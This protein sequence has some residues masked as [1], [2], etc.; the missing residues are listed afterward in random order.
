MDKDVFKA[1][2]ER[3]ITVSSEMVEGILAKA[4]VRTYKKGQYLI[5]NGSV[6]RKT[7]FVASGT[8]IAYF[9]DTKGEEH[10]IQF[11][12]EGWWISD[13]YSYLYG[14]EALLNV[15]ALDE[16]VVYEFGYDTIQEL[17][18]QYPGLQYYFLTITQNAFAGF[19]HRVLTNLSMTG[20]ERYLAFIA[21]YPEIHQRLTQRWIASY[22]GFSPEFLS[23]L[24][25]KL[26]KP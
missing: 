11:A 3:H 25:K 9:I 1:S 20:E 14:K 22:L 12:F 6:A 21:K 7:H 4:T 10:L 18:R 15:Q 5:Y 17:Y 19:Q 2:L 26:L 8:V 16:A 13:I 23:R 24:R